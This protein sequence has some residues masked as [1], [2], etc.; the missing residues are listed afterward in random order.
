MNEL[1]AQKLKDLPDSPG[2]YLM[3]NAAGQIIYVG[4]AKVLKNRV[5]QYFHAGFKGE[6]TQL[7]VSHIEDLEYVLTHSETDALVLES[8]LIK[9]HKPPY[10]IL[11]KDDKNFP[12]LRIDLHEPYP[13]FT[14]VRKLKKDGARY[15]GPF[16]GFPMKELLEMLYAAFPLRSCRFQFEGGRRAKRPCLNYHLGRCLGPCHFEVPPEQYL[17]EVRKAMRFLEGNDEEIGKIFR[18]RMTAAAENQDFEAAILYRDRLNA[19]QKLGQRKV[20]ALERRISLDVFSYLSN[21]VYGVVSVLML[22]EGRIVGARSFPFPEVSLQKSDSLANFLM[23]YYEDTLPPAEILVD[24]ELPEAAALEE[25]FSGLAGR[26]VKIYRPVRGQKK[27]LLEMA[28]K[29]AADYL[30]KT[31]EKYRHH[32]E[33]TKGAVAMLQQILGLD[34]LPRRMECYDISNISGTDKTASMVVFFDG[35][36]DKA[37]YRRFR[38]KTVEGSDDFASLYEVLSRRIRRAEEGDP[39][40]SV[41]PDL[42]V[43]DGGKGQLSSAYEAMKS[44]GVDL[45]MI[46]LAKREE[47]IYT[48]GADTPIRLPKSNLALRM[49]QRIRDE[50]HRFAITFHRSLRNRHLISELEQIEGIGPAKRKALLQRFHSREEIREATREELMQ[51]PGIS[52]KLADTILE[53]FHRPP[54]TASDPRLPEGK[55]MRPDPVKDPETV[56]AGPD[57]SREGGEPEESGRARRCAEVPERAETEEEQ[58]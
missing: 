8:N 33:M 29:N 24:L 44:L 9:K 25:H 53:F 12:Y 41:L 35:E 10:N 4:K 5:R 1:L 2:V 27:A 47:E 55:E 42:F 16:L 50:A 28:G 38:I 11:L 54:Q 3:K 20:A 52:R 7:M 31:V 40:F 18:Q 56:Q 32:E 36:P 39:A 34:R 48:V 43:I 22:R 19:L 21:G 15:F 37:S 49:L 13:V 14:V 26:K 45:S 58:G 51:T 6:K 57:S 46:S 23:Q 30:A 17:A